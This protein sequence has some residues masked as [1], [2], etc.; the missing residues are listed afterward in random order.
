MLRFA[1]L[2]YLLLVLLGPVAMVFVRAFD[3]G[4]DA[5]WKTLS[6]PNTVHAFW[7]TLLIAAMISVSLNA[8]TVFGLLSV[9]HSVPAPLSNARTKTIASGPS[10]T[11]TR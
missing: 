3:N 5:L 10:S 2:G 9:S 7:L 6:D 8:C 11:S 1:A 4:L